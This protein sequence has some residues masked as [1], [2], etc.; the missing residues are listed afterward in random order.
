MRGLVSRPFV[1]KGRRG[2]GEDISVTN[3][4]WVNDKENGDEE[5]EV[6]RGKRETK[7]P[8][9]VHRVNDTRSPERTDR[10]R[11][12]R[13]RP[14]C[15]Y[16][17]K[18]TLPHAEVM[19]L[20]RSLTKQ[21]RPIPQRQLPQRQ[22]PPA[23]VTECAAAAETTADDDHPA[24]LCTLAFSDHQLWSDPSLRDPNRDG[25]KFS[26]VFFSSKQNNNLDI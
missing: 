12:T 13:L 18:R 25:C 19:F 20:P 5:V 17:R 9:G 6:E 8:R 4:L 26:L 22:P 24:I 21:H 15:R 7:K 2:E 23:T 1:V 14:P 10:R 11:C 3:R 16:H